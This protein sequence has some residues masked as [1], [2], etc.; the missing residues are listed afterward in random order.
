MARTTIITAE[1]RA[2]NPPPAGTRPILR[3]GSQAVAYHI[4]SA[5]PTNDSENLKITI[6]LPRGSAWTSELHFH[7]RYTE[8]LRVVKGAVFVEISGIA[9][10]ISASSGGEVDLSTVQLIREGLVAEVPPYA[11]HN[12]GRLEHYIDLNEQKHVQWIWPEDWFEEVVMEEWTDPCDISKPLFFW[13]LNYVLTALNAAYLSMIQRHITIALGD[14][15]EYL[16]LYAIFWELDN[17][18]V[19]VDNRNLWPA[20]RAPTWTLRRKDEAEILISFVGV[21]IM[22]MVGTLLGAHAVTQSRTPDA[23]WEAYSKAKR[24]SS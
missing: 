11:R 8:Y 15:W 10:H 12:W 20:P 5:P 21:F 17:W 9:K 23:L 14:W 19:L 16:H 22:N 13:N 18:P 2:L 1:P 6:A 7:T 3:T 4:P 24:R